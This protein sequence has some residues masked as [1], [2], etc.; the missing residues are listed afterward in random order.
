MHG[1]SIVSI[2]VFLL[3]LAGAALW[4]VLFLRRKAERRRLIDAMSPEQRHHY[5]AV[6]AHASRVAEAATI[7]KSES[8]AREHRLKTAEKQ[9]EIAH[10]FGHAIVG[11]HSGKGGSVTVYQHQIVTEQGTYPM[12]DIVHASVDTARNLVT[13]RRPTLT[14]MAAGGILF[15][16]VRLLAQGLL[17]KGKV[18]DNRELYLMIEGPGIAVLIDCKPDD[19]AKVRTFAMEVNR[20]AIAAESVA[21]IR[22]GM[23]SHAMAELFDEHAATGPLLAAVA[24]LEEATAD[25]AAIDW[26]LA[27]W[28]QVRAA[29]PTFLPA[30]AAGL[31]D[32]AAA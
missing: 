18:H 20:A 11:Q 7:V 14:R 15:G 4:L 24:A 19:G 8:N 26:A 17:T 22:A 32:P 16:P 13:S 6:E 9:L 30:D 23:I 5:D 1:S 21:A 31:E 28:E 27:R 12:S 25:T 3:L 2:I 10:E 29:A